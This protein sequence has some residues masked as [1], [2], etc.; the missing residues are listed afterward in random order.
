MKHARNDYAH[1]QDN[2]AAIALANLVLSMNMATT[3]GQTARNLARQVLDAVNIHGDQTAIVT[4][5]TVRVIPADEPVFLLRGQD[6]HA[7]ETVMFWAERVETAGGDPDIVRVAREHAA[8]MDA[9]PK[10]KAPDLPTQAA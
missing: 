1:I 7:A 2:A 9:W 3:A 4:N 5:G 6:R 10:K 8:K